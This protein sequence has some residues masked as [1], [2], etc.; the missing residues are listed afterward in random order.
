MELERT[1]ERILTTHAALRAAKLLIPLGREEAE[2]R[3]WQDHDLASFAENRLGL[4]LDPLV[5]DDTRREPLVRRVTDDGRLGSPH[6]SYA[7]PYWVR[8]RSETIGTVGLSLNSLGRSV[9]S[10]SN[11]YIRPA[12]RGKGCAGELLHT[13]HD[14]A[15]RTGLAS[16]QLSTSWC[17]QR[18]VRLYC[19]LAM[20]VRMWKHEL[21]L[22]WHRA[23][24]HWSVEVRDDEARFLVHG[25]GRPHDSPLIIACRAGARLQWQDCALPACGGEVRQMAPATFALALAVRGWPLIRSDRT[26]AEQWKLGYSDGGDPEGLAFNIVRWEAW[27]RHRGWRVDTPRIPGLDY[28]SWDELAARR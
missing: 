21:N 24:P 27:A 20:W 28:P 2:V 23:L 10:V 12:Y 26:W 17:W 6:E 4:A 19:G 9:I 5:L 14:A 1:Q 3:S 18:A 8:H 11:L 7:L 25:N 13:I 16:T 22:V 15:L